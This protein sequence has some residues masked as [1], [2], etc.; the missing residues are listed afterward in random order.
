MDQGQDNGNVDDEIMFL[1]RLRPAPTPPLRKRRQSIEVKPIATFPTS[2]GWDVII[3]KRG[4]SSPS[5]PSLPP[6]YQ[7]SA[8]PQELD[9]N[10]YWY[11]KPYYHQKNYSAVTTPADPDF[12]NTG[13]LNLYR[14]D[15]DSGVNENYH[16]A[17]VANMVSVFYMKANILYV[18]NKCIFIYEI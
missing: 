15:E 9:Q 1:L 11:P 8:P 12:V 16:P 2:S 7:P 17:V 10:C 5:P 18:G 13:Y 14:A 3:E 4:D 6:K